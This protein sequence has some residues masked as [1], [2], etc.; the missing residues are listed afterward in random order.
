VFEIGGILPGS[1]DTQVEM[2]LGVL[3]AQLL[4][5]FAQGLIA[6]AVFQDRKR[7]SGRKTIRP[8][9]RDAMTVACGVNTDANAVQRLGRGHGKLLEQDRESRRW[10]D[11]DVR[12]A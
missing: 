7:F 9:E 8:E 2:S 3:L 4:E 11:E 12:K 6:L 1:V 5:A 10:R